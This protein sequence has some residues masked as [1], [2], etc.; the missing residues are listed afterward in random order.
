MDDFFQANPLFR[1]LGLLL[2]LLSVAWM[3]FFICRYYIIRLIRLFTKDASGF[4]AQIFFDPRFLSGLSWMLPFVLIHSGIQVIPDLPAKLQIIIERVTLATLVVFGLRVI[5]IFFS[6]LDETYRTL[7]ISRDRPI[8][9]IIQVVLIIFYVMAAILIFAILLDRSPIVFLSG[10]GAM[11][12]ILLLV[13]RDTI[14]SLVAGIQITSNNLVRVGD[15]LEMPQFGAD[16]DVVD[17]A[18]HTVRI[19]NWDKTYT[20]IPTHKFLENSFKNWRGMQLSGGRRIKRAVN[21]DINSVRFL[22][23]DEIERFG[24]FALLQEYIERKKTELQEFNQK[25]A[26]NSELKVNARRLTNI[27]TLRAY[28]VN[29]LRQNPQINLDMTFI[30]RQLAPGPEGL[31]IEIYVFTKDTRWTVYEA[32]Q[33]DIFDHVLAIIPE[34]GLHV[35]QNPTGTDLKLMGSRNL[36]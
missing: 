21:I 14:L 30:V 15:W 35:H 22:E 18:L 31:P 20:I 11:T 25:Y 33:A 27:G 2:L 23:D 5:T 10:L 13:F 8:K 26:H 1:A 12:A 9:G 4:W 6:K 29:Y 28:L 16:G 32:V 24:K 3:F 19:Q 17:I 36:K 7:T 34:F